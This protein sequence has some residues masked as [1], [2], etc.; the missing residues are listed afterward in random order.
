MQSHYDA[1]GCGEWL[2]PFARLFKAQTSPLGR[3]SRSK[4]DRE[5]WSGQFSGASREF[6]D[7]RL[8]PAEVALP[9]GV[10]GRQGYEL[11]HDRLAA[12]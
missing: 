12:L 11:S 2:K 6:G 1:I 8:E 9:L 10:V 5:I 7:L 3:T 4:P